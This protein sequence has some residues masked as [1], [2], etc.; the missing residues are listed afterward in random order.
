MKVCFVFAYVE[1]LK[2]VFYSSGLPSISHMQEHNLDD[3]LITIDI[4]KKKV[5]K[6][7]TVVE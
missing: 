7:T 1:V 6:S 5:M 4:H 3:L 2:Q